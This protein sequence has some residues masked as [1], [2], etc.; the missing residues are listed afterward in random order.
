[1]QSF[2]S[3]M[4]G[5]LENALAAMQ[6][7][8]KMTATQKFFAT[9]ELVLAT[10]HHLDELSL[11]RVQR[12]NRTFLAVV[13]ET[14]ALRARIGIRADSDQAPEPIDTSKPRGEIR[15]NPLLNWFN[16]SCFT[17]PSPRNNGMLR[18]CSIFSILTLLP[19]ALRAARDPDST[20]HSIYI[21]LPPVNRLLV[22]VVKEYSATS[23]FSTDPTV[24]EDKQGITI[25]QLLASWDRDAGPRDTLS[26]PLSLWIHPSVSSSL[27]VSVN[28]FMAQTGYTLLQQARDVMVS[29][30]TLY[31]MLEAKEERAEEPLLTKQGR[32]SHKWS[33]RT[34]EKRK[35]WFMISM[36][37]QSEFVKEMLQKQKSVMKLPNWA[38]EV[39]MPELPASVYP[40]GGINRPDG[41]A[42]SEMTYEVDYAAGVVFNRLEVDV[43]KIWI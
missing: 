3:A 10:A 31:H 43:D 5:N 27:P 15:W 7:M 11:V 9:Y 21:A 18:D 32:L 37:E 14:S 13:R 35:D 20:I 29:R 30:S 17:C 36:A 6:L 39:R 28:G 12:V 34:L 2:T 40:D 22:R 26:F 4:A 42:I 38:V 1:M 8:H 33:W 19:H 24:L 16:F 25:G 41:M 23:D